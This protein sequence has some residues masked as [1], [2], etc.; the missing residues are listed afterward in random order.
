MFSDKDYVIAKTLALNIDVPD[1]YG[2]Y[3]DDND[4]DYEPIYTGCGR[5]EEIQNGVSIENGISKVVVIPTLFNWVLKIPMNGRWIC[6]WNNDDDDE[7][8][9]DNYTFDSFMWASA[10]DDSDYCWD[11]LIKIE[12]AEKAGFGALFPHTEYLCEKAGKRYYIQEK[13]LP[14]YEYKPTSSEDSLKRAN[15]LDSSLQYCSSEWRAAVIEKYGEEFWINFCSWDQHRDSHI[16]NDMHSANY[17]YRD[18]GSPVI[19]DAS[20]FND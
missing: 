14:S 12:A 15:S 8:D 19:F 1:D 2:T 3:E 17:G 20:G 18:D 10:P 6:Q 9:Y 5:T 16:L 7:E 13:V 11:E 4:V